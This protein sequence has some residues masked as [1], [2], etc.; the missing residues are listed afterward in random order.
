MI[1]LLS[2]AKRLDFDTPHGI[3]DATLP[4]LLVESGKLMKTTRNLSQKKLRDLMGISPALAKLNS[5]RYQVLTTEMTSENSR[6]ALLAFTGDVY[7]GLDAKTLSPQDLEF[8]QAHVA[9]LSGL[10]GLLRSK[11]LIQPYRLEM[12]TKLKTRRGK[13]L[14]E[15]W[16][17]RITKELKARLSTDETPVIVNLAS[18][19]Y[20]K[21]IQIKKLKNR[22]ITPVFM[23]TKNGKSRVVFLFAKQA[24]GLMARY[25]IDHRITDP[26]GLKG[27]DSREYRFREDMSEGDRWV[28]ER[29]QPP[30]V[31]G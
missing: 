20:F 24:R 15:F 21:S 29:T 27:F 3:T 31:N 5:D 6:P 7:L 22:V 25:I 30:P 12:G 19:E 9:I 2:P 26:E 23:D 1:A 14:Y 16:G 17:D 18:A 13:S 10:Y 4:A 8:A 11:D 28:F